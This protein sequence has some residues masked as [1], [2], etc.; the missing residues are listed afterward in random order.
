MLS[1]K[2]IQ[3][4]VSE[5]F[6]KIRQN[7]TAFSF[8]CKQ[9]DLHQLRVEIKKLRVVARMLDYCLEYKEASAAFLPVKKIF[10]KA[11]I[12]RSIYIELNIL[13]KYPSQASRLINQKM[14]IMDT[15]I[16]HFLQ[17]EPAHIRQI[18]E[19]EKN[20]SGLIE[21]LDEDDVIAYLGKLIEK[22]WKRLSRPEEKEM[23][24]EARSLMKTLLYT[25]NLLNR[26]IR[27][28]MDLD[29]KYLTEL[30]ELIGKWHDADIAFEELRTHGALPKKVLKALEDEVHLLGKQVTTFSRDF[31]ERLHALA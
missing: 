25:N 5:R 21:D 28:I 22:T 18:N 8:F 12:I 7:H 14:H 2:R 4:F 31:N 23:L 24:H 30:Q 27:D 19:A 6:A 10:K 17:D 16:N 26:R 15:A 3:E 9:D 20:I 13:S 29:I 1:K 11:G